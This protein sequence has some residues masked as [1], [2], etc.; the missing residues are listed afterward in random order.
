MTTRQS[1]LLA[2]GLLVIFSLLLLI[3]FGD[4]G[5]ADLSRMRSEK[6][7]IETRNERL[8]LENQAMYRKI[9]RLDRKDPAYIDHVARK[10]LGM[11]GGDDV[12]FK[13]NPAKEPPKEG[14]GQTR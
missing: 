9:I 4:N 11:V 6:K 8:E 10:D 1:V 5:L 13:L 3:L 14:S 2:L 7:R 12:V